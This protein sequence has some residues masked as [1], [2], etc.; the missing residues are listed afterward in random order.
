MHLTTA[1]RWQ[2][3]V[4]VG[5]LL[6][7]LALFP[8]VVLGAPSLA[9]GPQTKTFAPAG[10]YTWV[11]PAG[12]TQAAFDVYGAQGGSSDAAGAGGL[13]GEATATMA[14]TPGSTVTIYVGGAGGSAPACGG[15]SAGGAGGFNGGANGGT[16][17]CDIGRGG[18]GGGGASDVR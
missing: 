10:T 18:G 1:R 7:A 8:P 12:V 11:V 9:A 14:V 4:L 3:L 15:S 13:G 16:S 6:S 5:A 2:L 17:L